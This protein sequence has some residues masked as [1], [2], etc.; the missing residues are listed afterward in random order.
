MTT[1]QLP[2]LFSFLSNHEYQIDFNVTKMI[3]KTELNPKDKTLICY[4]SYKN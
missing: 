1:E 4:I 3:Q 2:E